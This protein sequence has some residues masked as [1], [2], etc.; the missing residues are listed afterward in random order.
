M[1]PPGTRWTKQFLIKLEISDDEIRYYLEN[2][3]PFD[4]AGSYGIQGSGARFIQ[5]INGDY[6]NVVGLPVARIYQELAQLGIAIS[7]NSL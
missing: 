6:N 5:K 7:S 2:D 4:K 3:K 1:C